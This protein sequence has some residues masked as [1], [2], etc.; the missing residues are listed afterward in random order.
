MRYIAIDHIQEGMILGKPFYGP[1]GRLMLREG[2]LLTAKLL[3]KIRA[4]QYS[5][6]YIKDDFSAGI[7]AEDIISAELRYN[8]VKAVHNFMTD[9]TSKSTVNIE[10]SMAGISQL[11]YKIIDEIKMSDQVIVNLID[12]KVFDLYTYQHSVNVCVLSCIIGAYLGMSRE[13]LYNLALAAT[14]HDLGKIFIPKEILNKSTPLTPEE[15][16][17]IKKHSFLGYDYIRNKFSFH[18]AV[19]V[20][21]LQHHE[22]HDGT[23]YPLGKAGSDISLFARII[24]IADVYD[25]ITS[26]RPYHDPILSS[27]AYEYILGNSGR[28]F[29]PEIVDA[30]TK[31]IAPFPLGVSVRLSNGLEGIVFNNYADCLTRPLIKLTPL[32]GQPAGDERFLDLYKDPDALMITISEVVA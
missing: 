26:K 14:L 13:Q 32:P 27:E 8:A 25:A 24:M 2:M 4:L 9:I 29:N 1:F 30:F 5:G 17:V 20:S 6:L 12:L 22:R 15:F 28:H 7:V 3:H 18:I 19:H 31:K 23:G 10:E 11:L 16:D 21:I